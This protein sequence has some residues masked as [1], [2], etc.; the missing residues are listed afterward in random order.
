MKSTMS[1][2]RWLILSFLAL[3]F[4]WLNALKPLVIDDPV[5]YEFGRQ[6]AAHPTAPYDFEFAPE[7]PANNVLVPPVL[8]Y[9]FAIAA[10]TVGTDVFVWKMWLLPWMLLFVFALDA[11][12]RRFTPGLEL[13]LVV[14]TL[15][16]PTFFPALNMMLDIPALTLGLTAFWTYLR[17][18]ERSEGG[19]GWGWIVLSGLIAGLGTQTK[20]TAFV[21]LAA[22]G[23]HAL[24]FRQLLR[25]FVVGLI[26]VTIF[27][28]WEAFI[29]FRHGES[30]FLLSS[31]ARPPKFLRKLN[32]IAPSIGIIGGLSPALM[33]LDLR[34]LGI[35]RR[36]WMG[37]LLA[38]TAGLVLLGTVP[39]AAAVY[40]YDSQS[41]NPLLTLKTIL[42]GVLGVLAC[43]LVLAVGWRLLRSSPA[44]DQ[45]TDLFLIGWLLLEVLGAFALSPF[46]ATRRWMG[47]MFVGSLVA[48]RL[49]CRETALG[50]RPR[51]ALPAVLF[52]IALG[53][54][55]FV[56]D[57][58]DALSEKHAVD[59]AVEQARREGLRL[60]WYVGYRQ[61]FYF[62][63]V[64]AGLRPWDPA[65][66]RPE[67]GEW[68]LRAY[69]ADDKPLGM[70]ELDSW[71]NFHADRSATFGDR[72]PFKVQECYYAGAS[73]I[74]HQE[75]P[76]VFARLYRWD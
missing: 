58:V 54:L 27:V 49:L 20:Y 63:A 36:W 8:P 22:I 72:F 25:G 21:P 34:A 74:E 42:F 57:F 44:A 61:T 46:M 37:F 45:R 30:H 52:S 40:S 29:V 59:W 31:R 48:G 10:A 47:S 53:T 73:A 35:A 33:I 7:V 65:R 26:A 2:P 24:L 67:P 56:V 6:F 18:V 17:S 69:R 39:E 12:Y 13:P 71:P 5:Y 1:I 51:R 11:L 41:G 4:T 76:R 32:M 68:I 15:F 66:N 23:L 70:A 19:S 9:W 3:V 64:Q 75:G 62:Y 60:Q 55:L 43:V 38:V 16:S 14:L 28:G 50:E